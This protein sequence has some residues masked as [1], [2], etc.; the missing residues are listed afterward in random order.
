MGNFCVFH[1]FLAAL[2]F[3]FLVSPWHI[4]VYGLILL[5]QFY[6][7]FEFSSV[8]NLYC[9]GIAGHKIVFPLKKHFDRG[10]LVSLLWP[11]EGSWFSYSSFIIC[12]SFGSVDNLYC[13]EIAGHKISLKEVLWQRLFCITLVAFRMKLIPGVPYT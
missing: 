7:L 11:L 12:L 4:F 9:R 13:W 6:N 8:D 2:Y 5:F 3:L 10:C 1:L